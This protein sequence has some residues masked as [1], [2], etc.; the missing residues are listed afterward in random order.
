MFLDSVC[1]YFTEYFYINVH[2]GDWSVI[3]FLICVFVLFGYQGNCSLI[4]E[5][6]NVPSVSVVWNNLRS[7]GISLL[8]I[9]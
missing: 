1:Q 3:L 5:F 8:K 6:D 9:W 7:I 2:E 4:K